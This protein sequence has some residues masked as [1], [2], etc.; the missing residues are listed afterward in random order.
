MPRF[1]ARQFADVA[2]AIVIAFISTTMLFAA[3]AV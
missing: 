1:D 3:T 2:V